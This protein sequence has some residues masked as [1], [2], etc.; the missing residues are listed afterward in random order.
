MHGGDGE[1]HRAHLRHTRPYLMPLLGG[2]SVQ[3]FLE[4]I[5]G[6]KLLASTD[7]SCPA[8][9]DFKR[10][11]KRTHYLLET[12]PYYQPTTE[13]AQAVEAPSNSTTTPAPVVNAQPAQAA[14]MNMEE[15]EAKRLRGGCGVSSHLRCRSLSL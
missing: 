2:L 8:T 13:R 5:N 10:P 9:Y 3:L 6:Y 14:T 4:V 12:M 11:L 1:P 7:W 15:Q